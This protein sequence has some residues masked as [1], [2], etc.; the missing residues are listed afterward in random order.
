MYPRFRLNLDRLEALLAT[1]PHRAHGD[2]ASASKVCIVFRLRVTAVQPPW[3][4]LASTSALAPGCRRRAS[5]V[6]GDGCLGQNRELLDIVGVAHREI[7]RA[8]LRT[9]TA[10]APCHLFGTRLRRLN[11]REMG[12]PSPDLRKHIVD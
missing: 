4:W 6:E 12:G 9:A 7:Q 10:T 11:A 5:Q 3:I 8:E 1:L 2:Q